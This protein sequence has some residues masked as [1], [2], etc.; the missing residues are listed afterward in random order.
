MT[1]SLDN[2]FGK[3]DGGMVVNH[4]AAPQLPFIGKV[5]WNELKL[6]IP[7]CRETWRQLVLAGKAPQPEQLSVRCVA[8][9]VT[10]IRKWLADPQG[11]TAIN[12]KIKLGV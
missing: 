5:R 3:K 10:E 9:D 2:Y 6:F 1:V 12:N 7:V 8:W 4:L 11:Y